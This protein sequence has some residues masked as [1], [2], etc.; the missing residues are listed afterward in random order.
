[1]SGS[2]PNRPA[3]EAP[4]DQTIPA[5]AK[6][7]AAEQPPAAPPSA[8]RPAASGSTPPPPPPSGPPPSPPRPATAPAFPATGSDAATAA[9]AR[10]SPVAALIASLSQAEQLILGGSLLIV[11][12]DLVFVIIV[13]GY[14]FSDVVWAAAAAAL[15]VAWL[16]RR[17][18]G[19]LPLRYETALLILAALAAVIAARK[20]LS[21]LLFV[22]R[23]P[24]G[25][26]AAFMLGML[27]LAVGAAA[28][29][30][31]AWRLARGRP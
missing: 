1:M 10:T 11:L 29:A 23:P 28:M 27:G 15:F 19:V 30:M 6:T 12:V 31:G 3:D 16:H 2:D 4:P 8:Q 17:S 13:R 26:D 7:P 14:S 20:I 9:P 18:P 25:A 21:D 24:I 5:T 22:L